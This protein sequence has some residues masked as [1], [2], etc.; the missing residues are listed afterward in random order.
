LEAFSTND[1]EGMRTC[2][3]KDLRAFI[4]NSEG[5]MDEV[6]GRDAYLDRVVAMDLPA[7]RFGVELTQS[8]VDV[9]ADLVLIMVEVRAQ[10]G[11]RSLHNFAAHLFRV[12]NGRVAEWWMAD[13]KPAES[14]GFWS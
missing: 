12:A 6:A 14:D 5:G 1:V 10:K 3:A 11:E 4:T 2:L 9:G 8:P 7:V 13:A